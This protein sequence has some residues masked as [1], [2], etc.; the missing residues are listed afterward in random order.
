MLVSSK[1]CEQ[2]AVL[3]DSVEYVVG[4]EDQLFR[5]VA[6]ADLIHVGVD[7]GKPSA[8]LPICRK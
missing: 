7:C 6:A 8:V 5:V 2:V 3:L 1:V 4:Y